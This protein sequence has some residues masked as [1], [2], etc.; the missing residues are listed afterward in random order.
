MGTLNIKQ[1]VSLF[2]CIGPSYTKSSSRCIDFNTQVSV[3]IVKALSQNFVKTEEI[4]TVLLQ[5]YAISI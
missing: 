2:R 4:K 5:G 1:K 3:G